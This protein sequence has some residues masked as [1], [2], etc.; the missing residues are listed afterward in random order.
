[1][2]D[3]LRAAADAF[4]RGD[5]EPFLALLDEE[6]DWRGPAF[7]HL[8]WKQMPA[9]HGPDEA[10]AV[11]RGG[12]ERR[13]GR[14]LAV[15]A[16]FTRVGP[17]RIIGSTSWTDADGVRHERFQVLTLR[18]GK[19]VDLQ[20]CTSRRSAERFARRRGTPRGRVAPEP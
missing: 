3:E 16:E 2:I 9:C 11:L 13:G 17:D 5:P 1:V 10:R 15:D 14:P 4:N 7:G 20:G 8:W 12:L 6:S 18:A 19:I